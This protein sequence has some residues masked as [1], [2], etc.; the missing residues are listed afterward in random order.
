MISICTSAADS[1]GSLILSDEVDSVIPFFNR[2]ASA[3]ETLSGDVIVQDLG[4]SFIG[5]QLSF[6]VP[7]EG[8]N[9][10]IARRIGGL[11][12]LV[13][14]SARS[15]FFTCV[16]RS[17]EFLQDTIEMKFVVSERQA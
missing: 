7:Y 13:T 12:S 17:V 6:N 14:V 8:D 4:Y 11:H 1:F 3:V 15:G 5:Q 16:V 9:E 10:D 2:R